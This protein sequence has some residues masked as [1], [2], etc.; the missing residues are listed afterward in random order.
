MALGVID[1]W[2]GAERDMMWWAGGKGGGGGGR[3]QKKRH[4]AM[5][6]RKYPTPT[7]PLG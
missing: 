7:P 4:G 2:R 6:N 3:T 1:D 5:E